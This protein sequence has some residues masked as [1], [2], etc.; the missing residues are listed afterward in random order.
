MKPDKLQ[1]IIW[2]IDA[3]P[4]HVK[5]TE[6]IEKVKDL[7]ASLVEIKRKLDEAQS[8]TNWGEVASAFNDLE[9]IA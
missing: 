3:G 9:D 2:L 6:A 5:L 8:N 7:R 1:D 4:P